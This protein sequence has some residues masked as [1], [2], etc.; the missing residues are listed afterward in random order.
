MVEQNLDAV[1]SHYENGF[2][3]HSGILE[4][5][6]SDIFVAVSQKVGIII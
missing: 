5:F 4:D 3:V 2:S 1:D 6:A